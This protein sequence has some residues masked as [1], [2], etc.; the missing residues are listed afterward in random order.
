MNEIGF[1]K[2][3]Q[4]VSKE[5]KYRYHYCLEIHKAVTTIDM[6]S[7][8]WINVTITLLHQMYIKK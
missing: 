6:Q 5:S 3:D 4:F 2:I 7:L 1:R 8:T